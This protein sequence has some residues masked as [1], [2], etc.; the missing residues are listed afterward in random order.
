MPTLGR[1]LVFNLRY[2]AEMDRLY[3]NPTEQVPK[4]LPDVE[5]TMKMIQTVG[6]ACKHEVAAFLGQC[7]SII[8][9]HLSKLAN[10]MRI[11]REDA[12]GRNWDIQY[13]VWLKGKKKPN[14]WKIYAGVYLY[15]QNG[16]EIMPWL[17]FRGS[18]D[19]VHAVSQYFGTRLQPPPEAGWERRILWLGRIR[20]PSDDAGNL[21]VEDGPLFQSVEQAISIVTLADLEYVFSRT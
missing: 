15:E 16:G 1:N 9:R 14:V 2:Q 5:E 18:L 3:W 19:S 17:W 4:D 12:V 20:V 6:D 8:E 10:C 7:G 21:E 13:G 11:S